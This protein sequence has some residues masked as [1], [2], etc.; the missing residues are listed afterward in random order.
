LATPAAEK[1]T[2][3]IAPKDTGHAHRTTQKQSQHTHHPTASPFLAMLREHSKQQRQLRLVTG[4]KRVEALMP[5]AEMGVAF[6]VDRDDFVM[7]NVD[8][9]CW[10]KFTVSQS[11]RRGAG[12]WC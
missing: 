5:M 12:A 3:N 11:Y 4:S 2:P 7:L 9:Q 1:Y 10:N 6:T 8:L